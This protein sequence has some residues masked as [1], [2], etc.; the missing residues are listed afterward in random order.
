MTTTVFLHIPKTAGQTV[1]RQIATAIGRH[2]V[3]PVRVHAQVATLEAQFPPGYALYS[4]HLDWTSLEGLPRDRFV[5]TVLRDPRERIASFYFFLLAEAARLSPEELATPQRTGMRMIATRT[6]DDY[7]FGGDGKWQRFVLD[8]YDNFQMSYLA[9][10]KVRG[11]RD[12][13]GL[14]DPARIDRALE[15]AAGI[16][17]VYGVGNLAALEADLDARLGVR[18]SLVDTFVNAGPEAGRNARW[19]RLLERLESDVNRA[20]LEEFVRLDIELLDRLGVAG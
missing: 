5:F 17:A 8:H 4:G 12:L 6:A 9:T 19:P 7:F 16:D 13:D 15:G 20:R 11:L 14:P 3:S 10:R 1:H 2:L 18:V